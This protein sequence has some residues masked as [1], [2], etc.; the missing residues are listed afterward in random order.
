[1]TPIV[2]FLA[3]LLMPPAAAE[4]LPA[5]GSL[6]GFVVR[7][8]TADPVARAQVVL[9]SETG[10][11]IT[12]RS[13]TDGGG[14]YVF[15]DVPAGTYR[16]RVARDGFVQAEFGQRG[17][18][19]PGTPITVGPGQELEDVLIQLTPTGAI[20]GRVYDQYGDPVVRAR[21]EAMKYTFQDGRRV[22]TVV[23]TAETNDLGEYRLFWMQPG[24]YVVRAMPTPNS[25]L[26]GLA[27]A[28][29]AAASL[30]A[31]QM[32]HDESAGN[33]FGLS[34]DLLG[35]LAGGPDSDE[36]YVPVYYPGSRDPARAA[37]IDLRP[38]ANYTGV[39]LMVAETRT[40]SVRG[41]IINGVTGR[42]SGISV[43]LLPRESIVGGPQKG[44]S[45]TVSETGEFEI[46]GVTPGS[47]DLIAS[48]GIQTF[49]SVG[50]G[51]QTSVF[52]TRSIVEREPGGLRD[53]SRTGRVGGVVRID[54]GNADVENITVALQAGVDITGRVSIDR[55]PLTAGDP[56]VGRIRVFLRPE[57][58]IPQL[59][60]VPSRTNPDGT[61]TVAGVIPF[62]YRL[63]VT[64][65]PE[66][67][68]VRSARLGEADVLNSLLRLDGPPRGT[69]EVVIGTD[70]GTLDAI[71]RDERQSL[72]PGVRVVLVPDPARRGRSELFRTATADANG[73]I[74][75]EGIP[76]GDYTLFSW[77]E[78]EEGAW[79]DPDFLS[80]YEPLGKTVRIGENGRENVELRL[81][82][83]R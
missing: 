78:V 54:V 22:L 35:A 79:Q 20:A 41:R 73:R 8:G 72:V 80:I 28:T 53:D 12:L 66:N 23:E 2:L 32:I 52:V 82:P 4:Q 81:I 33:P 38:G 69:L 18:T 49:V 58:V 65:L 7:V 46:R 55:G 83:F 40:V 37:P 10:P 42:L 75:M 67:H 68:Y 50:A 60:P 17:P 26:K 15:E 59:T 43:T 48:V 34:G 76:P 24:Q 16:L 70:P 51:G 44:F 19:S 11:T 36:T 21:V 71:V 14:R 45:A 3:L 62:E 25:S 6:E 31:I 5:N 61:F 1:M 30:E 56:D 9:T 27:V 74:H 13:T 77:E 39:D 29:R 47:Y 63:Q 57:P 64:G